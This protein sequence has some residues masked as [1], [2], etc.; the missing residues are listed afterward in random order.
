M[1]EPIRENDFGMFGVPS[2]A[3]TGLRCPKC[4]YN[5]TAVTSNTCPECGEGFIVTNAQGHLAK[6]PPSKLSRAC[7]AIW[8][9]GTAIV[10]LSWV[11]VVSPQVGWIGFAIAGIGWLVSLGLKR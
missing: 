11:D 3:D 7:S 6:F 9:V 1:S 8:M 2:Q 4:D 10:I 5:L